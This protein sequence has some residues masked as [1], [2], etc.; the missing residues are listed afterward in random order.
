MSASSTET[1]TVNPDEDRL[2]R[3][4]QEK[5]E[6]FDGL[7]FSGIVTTGVY[8]RVVCPAPRPARRENIR[9]FTSVAA[10]EGAGFRPCL[11]CHPERSA[12]TPVWGPFPPVVSRALGLIFDGALDEGGVEGLAR[13]VGLG[14]RQLRRLFNEHLGAS[15]L[16]VAK[17]RRV[18][19]ARCLLD[20][21]DLS[22]T[23]VAL[24][25][26]FHSIRQFNHDFRKTFGRSP[27]EVRRRPEGAARGSIAISLRYRPPLDW[28]RLV[29]F[30]QPRATPGVEVASHDRYRRAVDIGG[31]G[32]EL[33]IALVVDE[34]RLVLRVHSRS[35]ARLWHLA[36]RARRAFDLDADPAR[37]DAD[38]ARSE[39]LAPLV[40]ARPGLRVPRA[41]DPF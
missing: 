14:S 24:A 32:C 11:R 37:I 10:A 17:A 12:G 23:D 30:L 9:F 28:P 8:C 21:T 31:Q 22:V 2:Y 5:A 27:K 13:R 19:F 25:A 40:R 33:E 18:H 20:E 36:D 6:R 34:P 16:A 41:W 39:V 26:G 4:I 1:P 29:E 7:F 35:K 38:L 15:P 3:A